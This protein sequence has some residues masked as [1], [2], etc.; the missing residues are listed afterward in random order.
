MLIVNEGYKIE[1]DMKMCGQV[2]TLDKKKVI[3]SFISI[4]CTQPFAF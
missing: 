3:T 1:M 2:M 4:R